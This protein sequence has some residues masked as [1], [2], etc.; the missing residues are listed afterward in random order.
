MTAETAAIIMVDLPSVVPD[1]KKKQAEGSAGTSSRSYCLSLTAIAAAALM[2]TVIPLTCFTVGGI[3]ALSHNKNAGAA[4]SAGCRINEMLPSRNFTLRDYQTNKETTVECACKIS[5]IKIQ[6]LDNRQKVLNRRSKTKGYTEPVFK[7]RIKGKKDKPRYIYI[8]LNLFE[9]YQH[10]VIAV[11]GYMK[12]CEITKA[13]GCRVEHSQNCTEIGRKAQA[14]SDS[15]R[16]KG[17]IAIGAG[18][19]SL[20]SGCATAAATIALS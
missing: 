2:V 5:G 18:G 20:A 12:P 3:T 8:A 16:R 19:V 11:V 13:K 15:K 9:K 4:A 17:F 7:V 6:G 10:Y 14:D 1:Q